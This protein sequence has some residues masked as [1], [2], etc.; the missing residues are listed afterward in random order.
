M[1]NWPDSRIRPILPIDEKL[2]EILGLLKTAQVVV[3]EAETGAG[4]TTRIG[5]AAILANPL[6][7]VFM[8]Q[9]RRNACRMNGTHIA[10]EIGCQPGQLVGWRLFD[11]NRTSQA[12]R[13]ELLIDQSL[14][15]RIRN[16]DG[17]PEGLIIV[18]EA[19]ERSISIDLLLGL[20][21][22][23][24]KDSPKTRLLITSATIDTQKFSEFFYKAPVIHVK[25]RCFPVTTEVL[26][27]LYGEHHTQGSARG[28]CEV[29][30]RFLQNSLFVPE[31]TIVQK[32][33]VIVLLPGKEDISEVLALIWKEAKRLNAEKRLQAFGCHGESSGDE[34]SLIQ[35]A[36]PAG[37]LRF[38]CATEVVRSSV[39]PAEVVG[40]IDSL[41]IKR[42]ITH[43][44]GV[45]ELSKIPVSKAEADQGKGRA[46]RTG[47]G[48]YMPVSFGSEYETLTPWP[49]PAILREQVTHAALQVAAVG[50]SIRNF[51]F[52]D[53]PPTDKIDKTVSRLKN[54]RAFDEREAITEIGER[55]VQFP[56]PPE[57]AKT[58]L[59]AQKFGV[60]PEAVIVTSV[61]STGGFFRTEKPDKTLFIDDNLFKNIFKDHDPLPSWISK[62]ETGWEINC[63]SKEFPHQQGSRWVAHIIRK[64]WAGESQSD[65]VAIVRAYRNF[66]TVEKELGNK[67][68]DWCSA[69]FLSLKNIH[70]SEEKMKQ[71]RQILASSTTP[72]TQ[73]LRTEREFDET[74]LSKALASGNID[75]IAKAHSSNFLG[76]LGEFTLAVQSA[77]PQ[78]APLIL[79]GGVRKVDY[80]RGSHGHLADLAAPLEI[81]WLFEVLPHLCNRVRQGNHYYKVTQD[82]VVQTE[83]IYFQSRPLSQS[84]VPSDDA[85]AALTFAKWLASECEKT[86]SSPLAD[87][88]QIN[89]ARQQLSRTLNC[90]AGKVIFPIFSQKEL[91]ERFLSHGFKSIREITNRE[92]LELPRVER[93]LA[94]RIQAENPEQIL[95]L[96]ASYPVEYRQLGEQFL[97]PRVRFLPVPLANQW[98]DLL[99]KEMQLPSGRA[100]EVEIGTHLLLRWRKGRAELSGT[101]S[102]LP[103]GAPLNELDKLPYLLTEAELETRQA[104]MG[105]LD[106]LQKQTLVPSQLQYVRWSVV[107]QLVAH[108][109]ADLLRILQQHPLLKKEW[110]LATGFI[111]LFSTDPI[112]LMQ[113]KIQEALE[114]PSQ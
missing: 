15:Q 10:S 60:L 17:L 58:L 3:C 67:L 35:T 99:S 16:Q 1:F 79:S 20:L 81:S 66:K 30:R 52:I 108:N 9:P 11:E 76:E 68:L 78:K 47:P 98:A 112:D 102:I 23:R 63:G 40:V 8:T 69:H 33:T 34:Q 80:F 83:K 41:Q 91:T 18:D 48:F 22:E 37:T 49:Q 106:R 54:L 59:T 4:K 61:L 6:L 28:A 107:M 38:V 62:R 85:S 42:F 2:D 93:K 89:I 94:E 70:L 46:G 21:K 27:L 100:L 105:A 72:L 65:F 56:L 26:P 36:V 45:G 7:K 101:L 12:T 84:E 64:L 90:R 77:C 87:I 92:L 103:P 114:K 5:Q 57:L 13:L 71:I 43:S 32:G 111:S 29:F 88:F 39:T 55:L 50:R 19:H 104:A 97:P 95:I 24:L 51:A 74:G 86:H 113:K 31:R 14:V 82:C 96:G 73:D 53:S 109:S 75:H 44:N 110:S 25:G